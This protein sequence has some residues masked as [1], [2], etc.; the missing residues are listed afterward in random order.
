MKSIINI[1]YCERGG[2]WACC[3]HFG[4]SCKRCRFL[5]FK[6]EELVSNSWV[7]FQVE[8]HFSLSQHKVL[9]FLFVVW[10]H[11]SWSHNCPRENPLR[12]WQTKGAACT[13]R[14]RRFLYTDPPLSSVL[15]PLRT[16]PGGAGIIGIW[17]ELLQG[18]LPP[19]EAVAPVWQMDID[20][21]VQKC[22]KK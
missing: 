16:L 12:I 14:R 20:V 2:K 13:S 19:L 11:I 1:I 21:W 22:V 18:L 8:W 4:G 3:E 17:W 10:E 15:L 5:I 6:R 9:V 7:F